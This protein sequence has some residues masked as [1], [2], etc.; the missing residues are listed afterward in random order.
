VITGLDVVIVNFHSERWIRRTVAL[1]RTFG[2]QATRVIMVDNSPGDGAADAARTADRNATI[3]T[4]STNRGYAAAV[5]QGLAVGSADTVLL[6]NPDVLRISGQYR[7]VLEA[8]REPDVAAV[9][10]RLC[11]TSGSISPSCFHAPR[12]IDFVA[13]DLALAARFPGWRWPQRYR[14]TD[15]DYASRRRVDAATGACLF[16]RRAALGDVGPFDERF[17]VYYEETD[18]LIRARQCGWRTMFLPTVEAVHASGAS[19]PGVAAQPS[20]LLLES[21]HRYAEKHFGRPAS[22]ALRAAQLGIDAARLVR[23]AVRGN[24]DRTAMARKR[25]RVHLMMRAPRPS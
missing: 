14:I 21:Q 18:W 11:D 6:L 3:L 12:L 17:F 24:T 16:L 7:D 5:N 4:N 25:I 19:S 8:F 2:G 1:A 13:Q 15:W 9:A 20:L 22:V 10:P 23:H